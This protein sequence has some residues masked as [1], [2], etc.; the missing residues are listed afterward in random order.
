M[1]LFAPFVESMVSSGPGMTSS[2]LGIVILVEGAVE[3]LVV[4][5]V[6]LGSGLVFVVLVVVFI[7]LLVHPQPVNI[8]AESKNT[9]ARIVNF[10]MVSSF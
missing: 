7:S 4:A 1:F 2:M 3:G 5:G 10:F 8:P 6:V 9:S